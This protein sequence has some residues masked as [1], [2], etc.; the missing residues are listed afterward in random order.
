MEPD[1]MSALKKPTV[2]QLK[3][4]ESRFEVIDGILISKVDYRKHK[5]GYEVG[6]EDSDGY[7][8]V[9][10]LGR[11][12]KTHHVVWYLCKGRWPEMN[13]DHINGDKLDNR[14]ENLRE[15]SHEQNLRSFASIRGAI[16]FRGVCFD[17]ATSKFSAQAGCNSKQK[18]L[19]YYDTAEKA[20]LAR[21]M[22]VYHKLGYNIEGVNPCNREAVLGVGS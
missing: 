16:P 8:V 13:L 7:R 2:D 6:Y 9:K 14:F 18:H 3:A 11:K 5:V 19:G 15:L 17:K 10:V 21:D 20:A 22:Y 1:T 12:F 4:I